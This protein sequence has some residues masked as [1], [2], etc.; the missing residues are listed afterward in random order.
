[1]NGQPS[2]TLAYTVNALGPNMPGAGTMSARPEE[3]LMLGP[4]DN[5]NMGLMARPASLQLHQ[6]NRQI[7]NLQKIG[8]GAGEGRGWVAPLGG[9]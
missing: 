5:A 8:Q 9:C 3:L 4:L 6:L 1:M 2:G 7:T